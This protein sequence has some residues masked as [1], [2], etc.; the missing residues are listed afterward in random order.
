MKVYLDNGATTKTAPE[1]IKAMEPY[2]IKHYGNASSLHSFGRAAKKALEASRA[3]IAKKL[4]A[5]PEEIIF[6]SGGTESNNLAIKGIAY[7]YKDKGNHII[8]SKIEHPAVL[9]TCSTLEKQGFKITYLEVDKDGFI[10]LDQLEKAITNKTILVTI[11][12]ANN[13]I[14][15]IEPIKKIGEICK[16]HNVFFHTDAVQSFTKVFL[17]VKNINVHLIS[18]SSH[19]I[20]GPKG[21]GALFVKKGTKLK[22]LLDGGGHEFRLRAGTENIPGIVGFAKAT[23]LMDEE[24][25]KKLQELKARYV[26]LKQSIKPEEYW[27][28]R[29]Y[30]E[31]K[32]EGTKHENKILYLFYLKNNLIIAEL[33]PK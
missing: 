2:F 32:L 31:E 28:I 13:E 5:E 19:K 12:H 26:V 22:K 23:E 30:Y 20:H 11:M 9:S 4:N 15:T 33:I 16:K 29:N 27:K 3:I 6:T 8:T 14:G 25:L 1:V 10:K 18:L 21:V 17:D 7:A 24:A